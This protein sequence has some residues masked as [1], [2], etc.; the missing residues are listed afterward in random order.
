MGCTVHNLEITQAQNGI[1]GQ[2][3][4]VH[5]NRHVCPF[6]LLQQNICCL[7]HT[8]Q[9]CIQDEALAASASA[10]YYCSQLAY[11]SKTF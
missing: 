4:L 2:K 10:A 8:C 6:G 3:L 7:L 5:P 11:Y 9:T 1:F